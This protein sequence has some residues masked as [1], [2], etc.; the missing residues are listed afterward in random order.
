MGPVT[1]SGGGWTLTV[2]VETGGCDEPPRLRV[3]ETPDRGVLTVRVT[4]RTSEGVVC[5]AVARIGPVRA[6]LRAALGSRAVSDATTGRR[7]P[8]RR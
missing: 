1:V 2:P 8:V 3:S 5:A 4:T 7:L 6:R